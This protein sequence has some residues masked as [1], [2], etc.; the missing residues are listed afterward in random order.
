MTGKFNA[1]LLDIPTELSGERINLRAF[2]DEDAT[3]LLGAVVASREHL[4]RWMPWANEHNTLEISREYVR[5][6]EAKW[7]LREELSMGIWCKAEKGLIGTTKLHRF[8]WSIPSMEIGYWIRPDAEGNGYV[9]E[10]V[11]LTTR[12]AFDHLC[13][14][15]VTILCDSRN[16]RSAAVAP[17]AGFIHEARLRQECRGVDGDLC[18][19]ELFA[20]TRADFDKRHG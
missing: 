14:E 15:R 11:K 7:I 13:A 1:I 20:M 3:N 17:R 8:D 9:T 10:A 6:A 2:R 5:R 19:T 4:N 12:F 18:D 16:I